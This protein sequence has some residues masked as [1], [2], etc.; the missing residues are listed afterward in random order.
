MMKK[1][2]PWP[3]MLLLVP[4][5]LAAAPVAAQEEVMRFERCID[6]HGR[7]RPTLADYGQRQLVRTIDESGQ[8]TIR[9]N[10]EVL[11]Q[12]TPSA[13]LFFYASQCARDER[14]TGGETDIVAGAR[15]ADCSGLDALLASSLLQPD[16]IPRLQAE[17]SS[18]DDAA[19]ARLSGPRRAFDLARCTRPVRGTLQLPPAATPSAS[20]RTRN[21][22]VRGC[23]DRL[24][25]C[26]KSCRDGTCAAC[27]ATYEQCDAACADT[28]ATPP[29]Q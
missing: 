9:Y 14:E 12:L 2:T 17:L 7:E 25:T 18:L 28:A 4:A 24:W 15:R 13:R 22:C 21:D 1:K 26:Q 5:L 27:L 19:W 20:E 16:E 6:S 11:P 10:P 29:G 3:S 8:M 23:A